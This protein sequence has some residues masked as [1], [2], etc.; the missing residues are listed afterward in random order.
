MRI[1]IIG[2][3]IS[4]SLA[5]RLLSIEHEVTVFEAASYPGGHANTVNVSLAGKQY[6]VDTAFMVFNEQT[7]PKL[8]QNAEIAW[9][10][11]ATK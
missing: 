8:L 10:T 3:G 1:A 4:G 7:Y 2:T 11:I 5:A 9:R 6:Q